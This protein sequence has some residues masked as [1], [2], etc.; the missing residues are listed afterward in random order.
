MPIAN[1][2]M[3]S[4]TPAAKQ[5]WRGVLGWALGSAGLEWE[6]YDYDAPAPLSA[7]WARS[8]LGCAMMCGLPYS[9]RAPRPT[10]VA[11]PLPSPARYGG[12][13][14]YFTDIVVRADSPA[15]TLE[16]TF[17]GVV[18]YTLEDSMSGCVALRGHLRGYRTHE[19]PQLYRAAVGGLVNARR[20]IEALADG[21]I[22]VGPLDSYFHDLLKAGDPAFA[23]QARVVAST[24]AA[25]IPPLVA[26]A[27]LASEEL[28]RLR[29]ALLAATDA[30]ELAGE[31]AT[32]LLS[33][34]AVPRETSYDALCDVLAAS[35][36]YA[37][38]W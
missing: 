37:G 3:Y 18:G 10:L 20:V 26:T 23:A 14:V 13:P 35:R 27:A 15:R 31:R 9:Q 36:Q 12:R 28:E 32:L 24:P 16:D 29:S 21:R 25:P 7:L 8:D 33:G 38:I 1:A 34:F 17:G 6:L 5:A 4:A 19:Q 22:D 2:R 11:A 30:P